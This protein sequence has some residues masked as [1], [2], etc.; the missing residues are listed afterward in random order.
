MTEQLAQQSMAEL[1]PQPRSIIV[2]HGFSSWWGVDPST[3][4]VSIGWVTAAGERGVVSELVREK[5]LARL[6]RLF[7]AGMKASL[8]AGRGGGYPGLIVIEQPSGSGQQVNHELEFAV[9][10]I[11]AGILSG[12][13]GGLPEFQLV[14]AS[15]WKK[16]ACGNGAIKKT[17]K[18]DGK[19]RALALDEYEV[20][21]WA[22]LNGY[23]GASWDEA[24]AMAMAEAARSEF[25][26]V[27]R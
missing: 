19:T 3:R 24:D 16:R 21:R 8:A 15:W 13:P 1:R 20:M 6:P 4:G 7:Q 10:A 11:A 5:G 18:V 17:R 14:V 2:P 26:L 22:M 25:A 9:G 23:R 27:E 12:Q